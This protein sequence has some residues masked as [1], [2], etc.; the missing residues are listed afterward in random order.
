MRWVSEN[1][2]GGRQQERGNV[3]RA[4]TLASRSPAEPRT[5][6]PNGIGCGDKANDHARRL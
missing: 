4:A 3:P 6:K 1:P 5:I 2:F